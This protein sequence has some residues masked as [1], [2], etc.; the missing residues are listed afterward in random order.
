MT[1]ISQDDSLT[2]HE[3]ILRYIESLKVGNKISVRKIA[4]DMEV[5]E[6]TA[7]RDF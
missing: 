1:N 5:S 3:Q 7:Y 6:G 2:K 4:K